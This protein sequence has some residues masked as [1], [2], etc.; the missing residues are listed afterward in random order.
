MFK[1]VNNKV[2]FPEM[3]EEI[4]KFWENNRIFEKS[5][6][7]T[8]DNE[9]FI[10]YDGPPFAT[11]LPH[12]GHFVPGILKDIIP[13][14]HTMKGKYVQ[15]RWGWDCHGLPV[16]YE[17]EKELNLKTKKDIIKFGIDKFNESCRSIVLR[18]TSEWEKII[19]RLG[20]WVDFENAYR[21][22]DL[23]YM[24]S[25]W[26]VFK[27]LWD[28]GLIYE[29]YKILPYC[30]RCATP[31][32]NFEVNQGYKEVSDP[33]I[34]IK[35]KSLEENNTY[36]LAWT[37]TPWTLPSN[38]ALA[39]GPDIDYVLVLDND[40]KEKYILAKSR[41]QAYYRKEDEYS[42]LK[43]FKGKELEGQRYEPLFSYF[44][45]ISEN[46]FKVVL[47]DY[48]SIE[49]GT[50]IVHTA[51]GF[52]EDDYNT[53]K[54]YNIPTV[55]PVDENGEFTDEVIDYKGIHVKDADKLI[56]ERLK[57]EK[58]LVKKDTIK[59][60]YPHCWRCD[61]PLIY[62]AISTWFVKIEP[63]KQKMID[64]NQKINWIPKHIKNGRF[65]KWLEG[66]RDWAISR[67][68]FWGT[69]LPVWKCEKCGKTH[70]IGSIEELEKLSG[71]KI[72][73]IH[74]HFV[75]EITFK[76]DECGGE[77]KRIPEVLDCWFESGSMPYAQQHYPFEHKDD[78]NKLFP[79]DFI[80]EGLDQTRGWFYTLTV[81]A[82]AL[83]DSPAF[84]NVI[85]N[86]LVLAEDGKKMSKRLKNY[87]EPTYIMN[88]YGAD[89]LRLYL[90]NSAVIRAE[91]LKF[92]E[93]GVKEVVKNILL[94]LWNS[95][96]FFVTYANIDKWEPPLNLEEVIKKHKFSN[97]LDRW[98]IS[99]LQH[100]IQ[101]VTEATEEY[102]LYK[103]IPSI[104]K[105]IDKLTNWYI[106]RSRRRFWKSE[107]DNDKHE[108]YLTLY[109]VL[110][111]FSKLAA[112]II[113]FITEEIYKNLAKNGKE[114]VHLEPYP[115][116]NPE[117]IDKTLE[118]RMELI[119][120]A[121][122]LGRSLRAAANIKIRQPLS[123]IYIID[124]FENEINIINDMASI[125]K[126]ELNVKE[127]VFD[128]DESKMLNLSAKPN[129]K[130]LGKTLGKN[131]KKLQKGLQKLNN[132]DIVNIMKGGSFEVKEDDF[133]YNIKLDD[134]II[135]REEKEGLKIL[136]EGNIT[137]GLDTTLNKS[138][139][140]EGNA[141][142][143]I[144]KIQNMR[145]E[146]KFNV[147]DRIKT[148]IYASSDLVASLK[149]FIDYI[150]NETLS[151]EIN[152]YEIDKSK[153]FANF[154]EWDING[155]TAYIK[156]EKL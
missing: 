138:L 74:K 28:K 126:E 67:N 116:F 78:F 110:L 122:R 121:T 13:R 32:S 69:P 111:T 137:V 1:E 34:T 40:S 119:E 139:I 63:I 21:T 37:T 44:K 127:V 91:E 59:H 94:P 132:N 5:L 103:S 88:K 47:A 2:S 96:S 6:E 62:K 27:A 41:L 141:R 54:K 38:L 86:G 7:Q 112:P 50:G 30:P 133:S 23:P 97:E 48:V 35:F 142:E 83:F 128:T 114:S 90:V 18:Y 101:E 39:V 71:K 143:I 153:D 75:D 36:F 84:K 29:G 99:V 46:A 135:V 14:Y 85:V 150:K 140:D 72:T 145:K 113:P 19:K 20:R 65:G 17:M 129:F 51:P 109:Y 123:K 151:L 102:K 31:L 106:R 3:E 104:L 43:E 154:K 108:A 134:I 118:K 146:Q 24:E 89:A 33:A 8:K 10:F 79:A 9:P 130:K 80:S 68:R 49:D 57:K 148:T 73:D 77:M 156:V 26:A 55:A 64:A 98:I 45:N 15:R 100:L 87:P 149:E 120:T 131:I 52:G 56:I 115:E 16:E 93:N 70:C 147:V 152:I 136:N 25:I 22:M 144:N 58:K 12:Y 124:S 4:V 76:C 60:N 105:F 92:S 125:I 42:I 81:I 61:S 82:A 66:A 53:G 107:N 11:G 95:Y 155:K 117:Q